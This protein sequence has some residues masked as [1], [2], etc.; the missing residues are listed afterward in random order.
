MDPSMTRTRKNAQQLAQAEALLP[1]STF[2]LQEGDPEAAPTEIKSK[3]DL[4]SLSCHLLH[5]HHHHL[6]HHLHHQQSLHLRSFGKPSVRLCLLLVFVVLG[7][8][9]FLPS[10]LSSSTLQLKS[11]HDSTSYAQHQFGDAENDDFTLGGLLAKESATTQCQSR[12]LIHRLRVRSPYTPSPDLITKLRDYEA[13]HQRCGPGTKSFNRSMANL[14]LAFNT[15]GRHEVD[16]ECRYIVWLAHSGL[17]NR[18]VSIAAAF[19]YALLTRRVLV[20]DGR[21]ALGELVCEPFPGEVSW[22]LPHDFTPL[23][24]LTLNQSSPYKFGLHLQQGTLLPSVR[25]PP[26]EDRK[27]L[28][29]SSSASQPSSLFSYIHLAHDYDF[30]DK[31][32]F[33]DKEQASLHQ[34]PWLFLGSNLYFVPSLYLYIPEFR[35]ELNRLFPDTDAIFHHISRYLFLPSNSVWSWIMRYYDAYLSKASQIV[36]VQ[37]RSFV[38]PPVVH[39]H[40]AQQTLRCAEENNLLPK[41]AE[42]EGR[43]TPLSPRNATA[44]LVTSLLPDYSEQLKKLYA[45]HPTETGEVVSVHQPSHE[46]HQ[47]T[48]AHGHNLKAWAEMCL[49]SFSNKLITSPMSTFGYVAQGLAG[50]KPWILT[51]AENGEAPSSACSQLVSM[52]PCFHAPPYYNCDGNKGDDTSKILPY[53][54][55]CEDVEWGL[56]VFPH[57]PA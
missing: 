48:Q 1:S 26:E 52:D 25:D 14:E 45:D 55:H 51:A 23:L 17:G 50:I 4:H 44:L 12:G 3:E 47:N 2:P 5:H 57:T 42:V 43:E 46:G 21:S 32:F 56:K 29:H 53:V 37:I 49:L 18:L 31:L 13:L 9:F 35:Q 20:L 15:E 8:F 16:G 7:T 24:T 22:L 39:P 38:F 33:C 28:F 11:L 41:I 19:V 34:I 30:F 10:L 36:G 27:S 54:K 40:L 6:L